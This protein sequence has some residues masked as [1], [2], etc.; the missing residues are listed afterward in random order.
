[1][2]DK[3]FVTVRRPSGTSFRVLPGDLVCEDPRGYDLCLVRSLALEGLTT[4]F[5]VRPLPGGRFEVIGGSDLLTA[6][7]LL[8]RTNQVVYDAVRGL[9]RPASRAFAFVRCR[10]QPPPTPAGETTRTRPES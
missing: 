7:R 2:S 9:A 3:D 1:M 5:T 8:V 4:P 6:V 10:L